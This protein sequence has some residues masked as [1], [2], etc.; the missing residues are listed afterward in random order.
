MGVMMPDYR[1][2]IHSP[3]DANPIKY[4]GGGVSPLDANPTKYR[5]RIH[6]PWSLSLALGD[7]LIGWYKFD[8]GSGA[9]VINYATDGSLG[10]GPLPNLTVIDNTEN[11]WTFLPGFGYSEYTFSEN[12]PIGYA[13]FDSSRC[14]E[15]GEYCL[16]MFFNRV[17]NW[18]EGAGFY[19]DINRDFQIQ[20]TPSGMYSV[21]IT[22]PVEAV[23]FGS[24]L[25]NEW[26]FVFVD[27]TDYPKIVDSDGHLHTFADTF[28]RVGFSFPH[29]AIGANY[30]EG[31]YKGG[32]GGAFGDSIIYNGYALTQSE[33]ASW[34]DQ[35]RSRYGM[36]A[37]SGW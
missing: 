30:F 27:N 8:E 34:Y 25:I 29:F 2:K 26:F 5:S 13:F 15:T 22:K 19:L 10:D 12:P 37:R 7:Y 18:P 32:A 31:G 23:S 11:F 35:L 14:F 20:I 6:S 9:T 1:S 3:L 24:I 28:F 17:E 21:W 16:G 4:R 33:W 36:A